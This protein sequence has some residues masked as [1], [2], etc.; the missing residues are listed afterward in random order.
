MP[1]ALYQYKM[2]FFQFDHD[3]LSL[4]CG[5]SQY[6]I[7]LKYRS[8]YTHTCT[9][10]PDTQIYTLPPI[11]LTYSQPEQCQLRIQSTLGTLDFFPLLKGT[12][13][14]CL[15]PISGR[16]PEYPSLGHLLPGMVICVEEHF[17]NAWPHHGLSLTIFV[18]IQLGCVCDIV[19]HL[20]VPSRPVLSHKHL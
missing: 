6:A 2:F 4:N 9:H 3:L 13:R 5:Y 11:P 19:G 17:C 7:Q 14:G 16:I 15:T 1:V 18:K 10:I 8:V 20:Y 12:R